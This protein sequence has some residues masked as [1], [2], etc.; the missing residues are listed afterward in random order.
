MRLI[1]FQHSGRRAVGV[2]TS[3]TAFIDLSKA[4][5]NLPTNMRSLIRLGDAWQQR[6][7]Q[8]IKGKAADFSID[9]IIFDPVV[10]EPHATWA[11]AL[12]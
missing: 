1:S 8:A 3:D 10:V 12:N 2:M 11:V 4:A 5:P 6:V 9:D 7:E